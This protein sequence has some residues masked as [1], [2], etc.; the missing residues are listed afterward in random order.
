MVDPVHR[1][2][3]IQSLCKVSYIKADLIHQIVKDAGLP[4]AA[5]PAVSSPTPIK[6]E[7]VAAPKAKE[8]VPVAVSPGEHFESPSA[9]LLSLSLNIEDSK[10]CFDNHVSLLV[11]D[12]FFGFLVIDHTI[13]SSRPKALPV[14]QSP[15]GFQW[16]QHRG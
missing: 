10:D 2:Q 9:A 15:L 1:P 8:T 5:M 7:L 3:L 13:Q 14:S 12:V 6:S 11:F 4:A 16:Q